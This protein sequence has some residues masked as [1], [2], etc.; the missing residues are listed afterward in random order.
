MQ[1]RERG[2]K[3]EATNEITECMSIRRRERELVG[4]GLSVPSEVPLREQGVRDIER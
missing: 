1:D 4:E 3:G 2:C